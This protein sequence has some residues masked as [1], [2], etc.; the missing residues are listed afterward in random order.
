VRTAARRARIEDPIRH[1]ANGLRCRHK[2]QPT[3]TLSELRALW[4]SQGS[5]CAAT[6]TPIELSGPN[7]A[8]L[9]HVTPVSQGGSGRIENLRFVHWRYNNAKWDS[10]DA[11]TEAWILSAGGWL[12]AKVGV[13][14][15]AAEALNL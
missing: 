8:H 12:Y 6:K 10:C 3:A 5:L 1:L 7:R 11:A 13:F 4:E 15:H 9:D 14:R 2:G